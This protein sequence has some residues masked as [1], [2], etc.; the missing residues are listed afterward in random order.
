MSSCCDPGPYDRVFTRRRARRQIDDFGR[1]G[2]DS[3]AKPMV[4]GLGGLL[5]G[6][7]VLEVGGGSGVA[8]LEMLRRG[9][10]STVCVDLS[11]D[12]IAEAEGLLTGSGFGGRFTR[13][14]GDFVHLAPDV[15][16]ADVVFLNRV[17]CCYPDMPALVDT[18]LGHATSV[19][20]FSY[21]RKRWWVELQFG[22]LNLLLRLRR[23]DFRVFVHDPEA[24]DERIRRAGFEQVAAATTPMWHWAIWKRSAASSA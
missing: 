15:A 8:Q 14:S 5:E 16:P 18:A 17:V 6:S 19:A 4:D 23:I 12:T 2:L 21:P 20:A 3:T 13:L 11:T 9:A 10:A 1:R 24:I 22:F 7:T